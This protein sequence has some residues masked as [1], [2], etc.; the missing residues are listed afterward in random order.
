MDDPV[1][2][3]PLYVIQP[4][5]KLPVRGAAEVGNKAFNLMRMAVAG[6]PVP[7]GVVLPVGWCG[8]RR[9]DAAIQAALRASLA[10]G[11]ARV[12]AAT[13]LG[14]GSPRRPLLLSVRSGAAV[15][16]T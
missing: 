8:M 5:E 14:F 6:L 3:P 4:R 7:P 2:A 9:D 13:G 11:V 16:S 15:S 10:N 1:P 12:E